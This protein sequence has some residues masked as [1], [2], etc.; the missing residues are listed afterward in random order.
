[1]ALR[2]GQT[3]EFRHFDDQLKQELTVMSRKWMTYGVVALAVLAF[4]TQGVQA[5]KLNKEQRKEVEQIVAK[6]K[7]EIGDK[8]DASKDELAALIKSQKVPSDE[9][10]RTFE[11]APSAA[12]LQLIAASF[13][14]TTE[15]TATSNGKVDVNNYLQKLVEDAK[16]RED[17][18]RF[19]KALRRLVDG[20]DSAKSCDGWGRSCNYTVDGKIDV[21]LLIEC[22]IQH[23]RDLEERTR[24]REAFKRLLSGDECKTE[25]KT[26]GV[27]YSSSNYCPPGY[28]PVV[29]EP[30]PPPYWRYV[31]CD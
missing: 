26:S 9:A 15:P 28:A 27:S 30:G 14:G 2:T 8:I 11:G 6:A 29:I 1:M 23:Q 21:N 5:Q 17:R 10:E 13:A 20:D 31:N 3:L 19:R 12:T 7:K 22:E 16:E 25:C 18:E 24:L 4:S